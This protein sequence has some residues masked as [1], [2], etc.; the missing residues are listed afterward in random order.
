M[1]YFK[2]IA[3]VKAHQKMEIPISSYSSDL[4]ELCYLAAYIEKDVS[5]VSI[6]VGPYDKNKYKLFTK[7]LQRQRFDFVGISSLTC[8]YNQAKEY[9]RL[10]KQAGAFVAMGGYHPSALP[11]EVLSDPN[12]DAVIRGEGE[13]TLK[14]LVL[15]GPGKS[16]EGLSFKENGEVIHNVERPLISDLDILPHPLRKLRPTRFGEKG[17]A[18]TSD[19]VFSSRGCIAKCTFCANNI[20]NKTYRTRS[21]EHFIEELESLHDKRVRKN[22]KFFDPIPLFDAKR[23]ES[24]IELMLKKNL[25]NFRI[26]TES[27][28]TDIL[29]I[30]HLMPDLKRVGFVYFQV[31][32]ESPNPETL[33]RLKKGASVRHSEEAIRIIQEN[34]MR[35]EGTFIIGHPHENEEDVRKYPEFAIRTGVNHRALFFVMTP[36]PGTQIYEEYKKQNLIDS[37]DWD[38][39]NNFCSVVRLKDLDSEKLRNLQA[40]CYGTTRGIPYIFKKERTVP[41]II[42]SLVVALYVMLFIYYMQGKTTIEKRNRFLENFLLAGHGKYEKKRELKFLSR[43]YQLF[44]KKVVFKFVLSEEKAFLFFF[45]LEGKEI[46]LDVHRSE[47]SETAKIIITANDLDALYSSISWDEFITIYSISQMFTFGQR[48]ARTYS[49][50]GIL[51]NLPLLLRITGLLIKRLLIIGRRSFF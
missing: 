50:R 48:Q 41:R 11:D 18:Y 30:K 29:R 25:T 26:F 3:L 17:D 1:S 51:Y 49:L 38:C 6:P 33:K 27:R 9:A 15:H 45:S 28:S 14:D 34:G 23:V 7:S 20:V 2:R 8:G 36:Y 32:L 35:V 44:F 37:Y 40:H 39:Y 19:M 31:G 16:I 12:V 10:A 46:K 24:I 22:L 47:K 21:P 43:L 5:L 4:V 42:G 13:L